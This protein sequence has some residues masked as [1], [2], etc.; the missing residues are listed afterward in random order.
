MDTWKM[1]DELRAYI[2][3][4]HEEERRHRLIET[5]RVRKMLEIDDSLLPEFYQQNSHFYKIYYQLSIDPKYR[6]VQKPNEDDEDYCDRCID[7]HEY[8]QEQARE[9]LQFT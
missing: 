9:L 6:V 4:A 8:V 2:K 3:N 5:E 7:M 1:T